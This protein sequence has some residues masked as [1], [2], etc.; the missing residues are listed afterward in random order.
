MM[1]RQFFSAL[2]QAGLLFAAAAA[3]SA[4]TREDVRI[5]IPPVAANE[6]QARFFHENF[7]LEISTAGYTVTNNENDAHYI[8][9]LTVMPNTII[10]PDGTEEPAPP[11]AHQNILMIS[12]VRNSDAVEV[13]SLFHRF[14]DLEEMYHYNLYLHHIYQAINV[15]DNLADEKLEADDP[16]GRAGR[17]A[18]TPGTIAWDTTP[19]YFGGSVFLS[20]RIYQ[21]SE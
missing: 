6:E 7:T 1:K 2:L 15:P 18:R 19:F 14:T 4:Q 12:L 20:P 3:A 10:S 8:I 9:Q 17:A 16:A 21:S 5:F 13:V 11:D